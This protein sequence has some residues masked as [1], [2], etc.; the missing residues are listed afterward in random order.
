MLMRTVI[1]L[2]GRKIMDKK[3]VKN[4]TKERVRA[5][6]FL[7]GLQEAGADPEAF[8]LALTRIC[9]N[10]PRIYGIGKT[11]GLTIG[12]VKIL[13]KYAFKVMG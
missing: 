4:D 10:Y 1:L 9:G 5:A 11:L 12:P 6:L 2:K 13:V 8:L 7:V 3:L